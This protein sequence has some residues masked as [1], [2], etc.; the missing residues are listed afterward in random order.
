MTDPTTGEL[1]AYTQQ[2]TTVERVDMR[3]RTTD[4]WTSVLEDVAFLANKI[5][6]TEFVPAGLRGSVPKVAAAV[7]HGRELGLPP[8]TALSSIHVIKGKAGLS[9]EVMRS[10]ILQA[11][12]QFRVHESTGTR[13]VLVARR[14]ND[15]EWQTVPYTRAEAERAGDTKSNPNYKSRPA[16]MLLAR[17]TTRMARTIFADVIHG[18]RSVEELEDMTE[19]NT[20]TVTAPSLPAPS[21]TVR[22]QTRREEPRAALPAAEDAEQATADTDTPEPAPEPAAPAT[23]RRGRREQPR[24]RTATTERP[25]GTGE[26]EAPAA[27]TPEGETS[28]GEESTPA[29]DRGIDQTEPSPD[30]T[31][32]DEDRRK[33]TSA[34][35]SMIQVQMKRLDIED[36]SERLYWTTLAAGRPEDQVIGSTNELTRDE[37]SLAIDRLT[38]LEDRAALEHVGTLLDGGDQ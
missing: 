38:K 5:A 2:P 7:L 10:L 27:G 34:Q 20:V 37:A 16:E 17:C 15:E 36:R 32:T 31:T 4:S 28:S 35:R 26:G 21:S 6:E 13:C 19:E 25:R 22:R 29:D 23:V 33:I 8:M 18:L 14:A 3:N 9:A 12:H 1:V 30:E 24:G 11:G